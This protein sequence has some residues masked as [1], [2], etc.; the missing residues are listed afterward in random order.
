MRFVI[1]HPARAWRRTDLALAILLFLASL[2]LYTATLAPTIVST[3]FDS[4]ELVTKA[5]LLELAHIPG[6]PVYVWLGHL[7]AHLPFGEVAARVNW[8]SAFSS[9]LAVALLYVVAVRHLATGRLC[10]MGGALLFALSLTFW[11]QAVIAELYAPSMALLGL[12][13]LA[14][15]EWANER[16]GH[17]N[18]IR[19]RWWLAASAGAF[20]LSLGVH[21]SN[22]LYLPAF[23]AFAL[24]G[25]SARRSICAQPEPQPQ[26]RLASARPPRRFD[27][28]GGVL[29]ALVG[30]VVV[31]VP[32][33]WV[34][35]SLPH[36]PPGDDFPRAAP[37]WPLFYESTINAFHQYRFAF[38]I[39]Q[40]PE[41]VGLFLHLMARNLGPV[42]VPL[43]LVG[44]WWLAITR[45]RAFTMLALMVL[46]N[47]VFYIN[48]KVLDNDVFYIPAYWVMGGLM[49]AGL[50]AVWVG[51]GHLRRWASGVWPGARGAKPAGGAEGFRSVFSG[52]NRV[53]DRGSRWSLMSAWPISVGPALVA[54]LVLAG[55]GW[56][57]QSNYW[58][59]DQSGNLA[60]H[61][62]W[63]NAFAMLPQG[64]YVYH[65]GASPGYDLLYYTRLCGVRPDLHVVAGPGSPASP[66]AVWPSG[67][68]F[69]GVTKY[70]CCLPDF[71][72]ED[73][74]RPKWYEPVLTGMFRWQ[75][76][77]Q[78]G[79][80]NLFRVRAPDDV[81]HDWMVP[82]DDPASHPSNKLDNIPYTS[83]LV[84]VG[85]DAEPQAYAGKPWRIVRYWYSLGQST[86]IP[87]M[88]TILG[89]YEAVESHVPLFNQL[90]DYVQARGI[91][92]MGLY[93]IKDEVNLVIPSNLPPGK[94]KIRVA[95]A[96]P[97]LVTDIMLDPAP[98]HELVSNEHVVAE[99]Q[100]VT[101]AQE[102]LH[103]P[104]DPLAHATNPMCKR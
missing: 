26:P 35:F 95:R 82:I 53:R 69:S 27:V 66:P 32:Y 7:F 11:S 44:V 29:A 21:P 102:G 5:G 47:V 30:L 80:L 67:P 50:K 93:V 87:P 71:V 17:N 8:L 36:M 25:L 57:W 23:A 6:S 51:V 31:I 12:S 86:W 28:V 39:E 4:P 59:N 88:V 19:A 52:A 104:P 60:F 97:R 68:V 42:G 92:D 46:A 48:Y 79:W 1:L 16:S 94:Y 65:R 41:R 37:G 75:H 77:M 40:I 85:V 34:Y 3:S 14:L 73:G 54:L 56:Q 103:S 2:A 98:P 58:F 45:L 99:V 62:F 61:D 13:V 33:T 63:G 22:L 10:A 100:V 84:L 24:M 90:A 89:D 49:A 72:R 91:S 15:L 74:T 81:P 9:A 43:M 64:A 20:G 76:G 101:G 55:A 96:E 70:D 78:Y 83:E 38:P 18:S